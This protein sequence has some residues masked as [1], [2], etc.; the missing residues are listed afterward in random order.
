M[1]AARA[2]TALVPT[3][4]SALGIARRDCTSS[5]AVGE[6]TDGTVIENCIDP[7][8]ATAS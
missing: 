7:Y 2:H 4:Q 5:R 1:L 6:A 8:T 3:V